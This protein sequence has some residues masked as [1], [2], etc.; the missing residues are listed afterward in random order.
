MK[1]KKRKKKQKTIMEWSGKTLPPFGHR[2]AILIYRPPY[3]AKHPVPE[4]FLIK[5]Q[6]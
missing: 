4:D 5:V 6:K 2:T 3:P 1:R